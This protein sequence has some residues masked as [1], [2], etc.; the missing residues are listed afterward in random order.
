MSFSSE[1]IKKISKEISG[2]V[3][4][5]TLFDEFSRGRYSTTRYANTP[6]KTVIGSLWIDASP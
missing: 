5:K 1:Q 4:G 3:N 6:K 2:K